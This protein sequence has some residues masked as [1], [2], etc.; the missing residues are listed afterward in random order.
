MTARNDITGDKIATKTNSNAYRDN[1][2]AIFG[3]KNSN[4]GDGDT[5]KPADQAD[6]QATAR[7]EAE[8]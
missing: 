3:K 5:S 6:E 4:A 2:D 1:W 8:T 7:P